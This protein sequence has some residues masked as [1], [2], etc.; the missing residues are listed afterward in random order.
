L[1]PGNGE[2]FFMARQG[3][4]REIVSP[5]WNRFEKP[6]GVN[7]PTNAV[8]YLIVK[9]LIQVS[10]VRGCNNDPKAMN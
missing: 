7:G 6:A 2:R 3:G 8:Q 1:G 9:I 5:P 4:R 10:R